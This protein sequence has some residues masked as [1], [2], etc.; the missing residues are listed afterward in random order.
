MS[1]SVEKKKGLFIV[2]EGVDGSGISTQAARLHRWL[3]ERYKS[4][5]LLTK[6]PSDGPI[7]MSVRQ[8][9]TGRIKDVAPDTLALLF[10]ADR[11]DHVQQQILPALNQG[12]HVICDR[13]LLSSLAYQGLDLNQEWVAEINSHALKPDVTIF[14]RVSPSTTLKRIRGN[15]FHIDLFE[16]E[17]TLQRVLANYDLLLAKERAQGESVIEIDGEHPIDWVTQDIQAHLNAYL[18]SKGF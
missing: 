13:Y 12:H 11:L 15:R 4:K 3:E 16:Q 7:G 10:A 2:L 6:E 8:V 18:S 14:I 1:A 5:V 9:L 17:N